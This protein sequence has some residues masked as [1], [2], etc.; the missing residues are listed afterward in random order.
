MILSRDP[1]TETRLHDKGNKVSSSVHFV[2]PAI[3]KKSTLQLSPLRHLSVYIHMLVCSSSRMSHKRVQ[4]N[5]RKRRQERVEVR[6]D[7]NEAKDNESNDDISSC[8]KSQ[9]MQNKKTSQFLSLAYSC[10]MSVRGVNGT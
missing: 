8:M 4:K 5:E 1:K 6:V 10:I 9:N 3:K 2:L 7:D